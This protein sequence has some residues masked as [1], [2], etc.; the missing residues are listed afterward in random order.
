LRSS[1][2]MRGA[3]AS[4]TSPIN[5]ERLHVEEIWS[6][7]FVVCL[8]ADHPLAAHSSL[9][10]DNLKIVD[11][12]LVTSPTPNSVL[13]SLCIA[14]HQFVI[15]FRKG[16]PLA[17]RRSVT[18]G[19]IAGYPWVFFKRVIHPFLHVLMPISL[20][21]LITVSLTHGGILKLFRLPVRNRSRFYIRVT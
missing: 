15:T 5:D 8:R 9:Q 20:R 3:T 6:D 4:V 14:T 11:L 1:V 10:A 12:A 19:E 2:A 13:T 18:L 17:A 16:H 7:R 21:P